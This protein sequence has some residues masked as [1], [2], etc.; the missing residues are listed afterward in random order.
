[1]TLPIQTVARLCQQ[2]LSVHN[3]PTVLAS[4]TRDSVLRFYLKVSLRRFIYL[5]EYLQKGP[6]RYRK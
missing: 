2:I 1:M 5:Y 6:K 4:Y 3:K